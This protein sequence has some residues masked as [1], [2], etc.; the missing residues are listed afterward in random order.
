MSVSDKIRT[1]RLAAG[2]TQQAAADATG[3][4]V[5]QWC[6]WERGSSPRAEMLGRLAIALGVTLEALVPMPREED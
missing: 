3:V 5:T 4:H 2:L 1:A 6:R